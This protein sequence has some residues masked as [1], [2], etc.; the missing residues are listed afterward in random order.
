MRDACSNTTEFDTIITHRASRAHVG[1]GIVYPTR[2]SSVVEEFSPTLAYIYNCVTS[3]APAGTMNKLSRD[4][5]NGRATRGV[6]ITT[7][8][9]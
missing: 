4:G 6:E 5:Q 1:L 8:E 2:R 3:L 7:S 9:V